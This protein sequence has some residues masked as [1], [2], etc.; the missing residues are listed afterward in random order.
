MSN[1][2]RK[3]IST[4]FL[5]ASAACFEEGPAASIG[6]VTPEEGGSVFTDV[7]VKLALTGV[8]LDP[9]GTHLHLMIDEPCLTECQTITPSASRLDLGL[10]S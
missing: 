1:V 7:D 4:L 9:Q 2:V 3:I 5:A 8:T 6:F 10:H